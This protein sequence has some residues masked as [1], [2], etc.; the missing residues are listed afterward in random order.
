[1]IEVATISKN[2]IPE[3]EVLQIFK[4]LCEGVRAFHKQNPPLAHRDIKV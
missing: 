1:M 4:S 3:K 2:P